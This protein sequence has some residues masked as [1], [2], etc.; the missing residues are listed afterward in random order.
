MVQYVVVS[1]R[2]AV[3]CCHTKKHRHKGGGNNLNI[4]HRI[5]QDE[6]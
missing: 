3:I 5:P 2:P 1:L 6:L 4:K